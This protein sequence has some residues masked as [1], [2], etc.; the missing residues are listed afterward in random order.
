MRRLM[1]LV[2]AVAVT[3]ASAVLVAG[4]SGAAGSGQTEWVI[5]D[6][7]TLGGKGSAAVAINERGRV[8]GSSGTRGCKRDHAFL[9]ESGKMRDLGSEWGESYAIAI[10]ENG[11]VIG[12]DA[13]VECDGHEYMSYDSFFW[14]GGKSVLI[15]NLSDVRAVND[16]GG[17]ALAVIARVSSVLRPDALAFPHGGGC[18][19]ERLARCF[20]GLSG[21]PANRRSLVDVAV[22][23]GHLERVERVLDPLGT[24]SRVIGV[25]F[26]EKDG[27]LVACGV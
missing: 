11:Q 20:V 2:G 26:W 5:R 7:G 10:S 16:G 24:H 22:R 9:W 19:V 17:S 1:L 8:V 18:P 3:V 25:G 13:P 14:Q 27:E 6:L 12:G 21:C 23:G 4:A 15:G